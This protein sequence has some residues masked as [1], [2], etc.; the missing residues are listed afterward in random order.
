[1]YAKSINININININ[2]LFVKAIAIT[3]N[4]YGLK[5]GLEVSTKERMHR[6][7]Y[8]NCGHRMDMLTDCVVIIP[9]ELCR[10]LLSATTLQ[11][12]A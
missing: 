3:E 1:M 9:L 8:L 6:Q 7:T 2:F 10:S 4:I 12:G 11:T 5:V